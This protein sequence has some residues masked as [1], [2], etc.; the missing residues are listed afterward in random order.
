MGGDGTITGIGWQRSGFYPPGADCTGTRIT[1]G[2]SEAPSLGEL[3]DG[4]FVEGS[5]TV[6]F[7]EEIVSLAAGEDE[8]IE[9]ELEQPFPYG[10]GN[11]LLIEVVHSD[12]R[13]GMYT[14]HWDSGADRALVG[15]SDDAVRGTLLHDLPHMQ[16]EFLA[17][18]LEQATFGSIKTAAVRSGLTVR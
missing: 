14:W 16:L 6:V 13:G 5:A 15:Y 2:Y 1:L 17:T 18:G 4:N 3:F 9:I 8:W 10:E 11:H 12:S 7:D